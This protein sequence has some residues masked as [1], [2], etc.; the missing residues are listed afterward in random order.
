MLAWHQ[1]C[2]KHK[3]SLSVHARVAA[4]LLQAEVVEKTTHCGRVHANVESIPPRMAAHWACGVRQGSITALRYWFC[5]LSSSPALAAALIATCKKHTPN[6][7]KMKISTTK[8]FLSSNTLSDV[9]VHTLCP[10]NPT[11]FVSSSHLCYPSVTPVL[12]HVVFFR[13]NLSHEVVHHN[14]RCPLSIL[15]RL[16][17]AALLPRPS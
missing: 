7:R 12:S 9:Q 4:A 13:R 2:C 1:R 17:A 3:L 15:F 10:V 16:L 5:I 11:T 14:K 8:R 6:N